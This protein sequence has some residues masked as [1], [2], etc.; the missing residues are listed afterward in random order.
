MRKLLLKLQE[1][2]IRVRVDTDAQKTTK[3]GLFLAYL[4]D[5]VEIRMKFKYVMKSLWYLL[6][7]PRIHYIQSSELF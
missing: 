1:Q 2:M 7:Q 6:P 3:F 5:C 4:R